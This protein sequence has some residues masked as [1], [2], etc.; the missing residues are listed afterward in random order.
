M[1][2]SFTASGGRSFAI[3]VAATLSVV[4]LLAGC[5]TTSTATNRAASYSRHPDR[6]FIVDELNGFGV[7]FPEE[8]EKRVTAG[9]TACG[10][11]VEFAHVNA[12]ELDPSARQQQATRFKPDV[13]VTMRVTHRTIDAYGSL[14]NADVDTQVWDVTL[15]KMVWRGHSAMNAGGMFTPAGTRAESLY[16]NLIGKMRADGVVPDCV[17][18]TPGTAGSRTGATTGF[19]SNIQRGQH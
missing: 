14:L 16:A 7:S 15:R 3:G 9:I 6:I 13:I 5:A 18:G 12:L 2:T 17:G 1:N 8:F 11:A 10:G 19:T 4:S